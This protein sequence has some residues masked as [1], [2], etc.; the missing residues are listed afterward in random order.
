MP[1]LVARPVMCPSCRRVLFKVTGNLTG[2]GKIETKCNRCKRI[3]AVRATGEEMK[4]A[5]A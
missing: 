1:A 2:D 4:A 3:V 5:T